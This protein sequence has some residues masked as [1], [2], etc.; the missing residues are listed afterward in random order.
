YFETPLFSA[1]GKTMITRSGGPLLVWDLAG[2]KI[3]RTVPVGDM[4]FGHTALSPDGKR[5]VVVGMPGFDWKGVGR[6]PDPHDLPQPRALLIDLANPRSEP[7]VLIL[8]SG[9]V[10]GVALSPDGNTLA[11]G[12]AGAV[13]LVDVSGR[14][15]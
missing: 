15:K 6:N 7:E 2:K 4:P 5:A 11:V 1:D 8:P 13:H 12:G 10:G 3:A 14:R 9:G